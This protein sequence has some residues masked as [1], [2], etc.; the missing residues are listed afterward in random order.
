MTRSGPTLD[1]DFGS[2]FADSGG[3][4]GFGGAQSMLSWNWA[5]GGGNEAWDIVP[6]LKCEAAVAVGLGAVAFT[7]LPCF[8]L[9]TSGACKAWNSVNA[10]DSSSN[11]KGTIISQALGR[12]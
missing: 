6:N 2:R 9:V 7:E 11:C 5:S 8:G 12:G 3:A 10:F 4:T 1:S